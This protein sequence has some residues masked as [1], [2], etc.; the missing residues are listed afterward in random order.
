MVSA[1]ST[2]VFEQRYAIS[3][4]VSHDM[5]CQVRN[6]LRS[7]YSSYC[8]SRFSESCYC[9]KI[10]MKIWIIYTHYAPVV[11]GIERV[12]FELSKVFTQMGN[13]T[14]IITL[15][16]PKDTG[17]RE[18]AEI[19]HVPLKSRTGTRVYAIYRAKVKQRIKEFIRTLSEN[20][21]PDI[22]VAKSAMLA[23]ILRECGI[24]SPIVYVPGMDMKF[25]FRYVPQANDKRIKRLLRVIGSKAEEF[26][27]AK[28][29][30]YCL[31][32]IVL[33]E[34][35]RNQVVR[36]CP[37]AT[38]KVIV[39]KPGCSLPFIDRPKD[40]KRCKR[41]VFVGRIVPQKNT[42]MLIQALSLLKDEQVCLTITGDGPSRAG[43]E[44]L[45]SQN[46]M[47]SRVRITGFTQ[48]VEDY[49]DEADYLVLPSV[50]EP[51]GLV[52]VEAFTRATPV[53][54]FSTIEGQTLT[55]NDELIEDGRTGFLCKQ[56]SAQALADTLTRAL[57]ITDEQYRQMCEI[58]L[59]TALTDYNWSSFARSVLGL[60]D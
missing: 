26:E 14:S 20:D 40:T 21:F 15:D 60:H 52:V 48:H 50:Y 56:F 17:R 1:I 18:Y 54:G 9:M 6:G 30:K 37:N 58:C 35:M 25:Y 12:M 29:I 38:D 51:F 28:A 23:N 13:P 24:K 57:A 31:R 22:V 47:Q 45:I 39:S 44:K 34:A 16:E 36:H 33:C 46:N 59:Q 32:T 19:Y 41:L 2:G 5:Q 42:E 43:A 3:V 55:N 8:L 4:I 27:D 11:G 53:I 10:D 49:I 7:E